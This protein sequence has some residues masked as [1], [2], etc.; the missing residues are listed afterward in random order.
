M[1]KRAARKETAARAS[2]DKGAARRVPDAHEFDAELLRVVRDM[3]Q[4][5]QARFRREKK[6]NRSCQK[7]N[8]K[9]NL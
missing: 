5:E 6:E 8:R 9:L 3:P 4:R 7:K 2:D 1:E